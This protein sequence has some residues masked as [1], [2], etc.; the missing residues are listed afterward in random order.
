M[1]AGL[2]ALL[3]TWM[4]EQTNYIDE[5]TARAFLPYMLAIWLVLSILL[6]IWPKPKPKARQETPYL[7]AGE[8]LKSDLTDNLIIGYDGAKT[9]KNAEFRMRRT[10]LESGASPGGSGGHGML[11]AGG[12]NCGCA[13]SPR[14]SR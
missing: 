5:A 6:V 14:R 2:A 8:R 11:K 13:T 12:P 1:L 3:A 7:E 4:L 9:A 10:T